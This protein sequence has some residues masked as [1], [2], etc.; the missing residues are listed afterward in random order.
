MAQPPRHLARRLPAFVAAAALAVA[1]LAVA[2]AGAAFR[3]A[4]AGGHSK[5]STPTIVI[6]TFSF[7]PATLKV[8][9]G[10]TVK[11]VNKTPVTHTVTSLQHKFNTGDVSGNTSTTFKA[12]TKAGRYGYQCKIHPYMT[13]VLVV[14]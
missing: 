13:G 12:P 4:S 6:K 3:V 10:Q 7:S 1:L 8:K 9:P 11:V 2:P 14:T 5:T